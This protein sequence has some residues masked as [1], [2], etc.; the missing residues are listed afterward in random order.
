M[1]SSTKARNVSSLVNQNTG[2][3]NKKAG[4]A[5]QVGRESYTSV[6]MG[7]K[8]GIINNN[9]CSLKKLQLTFN[10]N[11]KISRPVGS[12]IGNSGNTYWSIPK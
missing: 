2:G 10:P 3:G 7:T 12:V 4:L 5:Y 8:T 6:I 1:N 9:C 11:V